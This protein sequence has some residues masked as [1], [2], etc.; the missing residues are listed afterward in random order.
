MVQ[1]NLVLSRKRLPQGLVMVIVNATTNRIKEKAL[2]E[3]ASK[4]SASAK[5]VIPFRARCAKNVIPFRARCHSKCKTIIRVL[6]RMRQE[7]HRA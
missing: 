4:V 5:N 1:S 6:P 3:P 2:T 7:K